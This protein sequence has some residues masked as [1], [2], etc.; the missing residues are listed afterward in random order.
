MV[1]AAVFNC[2]SRARFDTAYNTT[3]QNRIVRVFLELSDVNYF[4][5]HKPWLS[6][7]QLEN[8]QPHVK[9]A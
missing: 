5:R 2:A 9:Y 3:M 4:A 6:A 7:E 1:I 8:K